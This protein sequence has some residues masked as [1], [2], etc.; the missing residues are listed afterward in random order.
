VSLANTVVNY[1]KDT[2]TYYP[3]ID[4]LFSVLLDKTKP[5]SA[6]EQA[7]SD[8]IDIFDGLEARTNSKSVEVQQMTDEIHTVSPRRVCPFEIT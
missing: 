3:A 8:L 2:E 6:R 1:A 5:E 4:Q 7:A